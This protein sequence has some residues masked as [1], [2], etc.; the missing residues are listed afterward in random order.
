DLL[1]W[2]ITRRQ[3]GDHRSDHA[4]AQVQRHDARGV[5]RRAG[6]AAD[7]LVR[8]GREQRPARGVVLEGEA[9]R[10]PVGLESAARGCGLADRPG[11]LV[12]VAV[13]YREARRERIVRVELAYAR[14]LGGVVAAAREAGSGLEHPHL[15]NVLV[16]EEGDV[17]REIQA[18]REHFHLVAVRDDD[19]LAVSWVELDGFDGTD[20]VGYIG[21]DRRQ[22]ESGSP[23]KKRDRSRASRR[24]DALHEFLLRKNFLLAGQLDVARSRSSA[25][26]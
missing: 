11:E 1:G 15:E 21:G 25:N 24:N 26:I 18:L 9:D 19:V 5:V 4:V 6:R 23:D 10:R 17:G 14:D 20:R 16:A 2:V 12:A 13:E 8:V 7:A 3:P 22:R